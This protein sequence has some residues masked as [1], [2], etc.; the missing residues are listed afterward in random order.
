VIRYAVLALVVCGCA[1]Q[2]PAVRPAADGLS[3]ATPP[4]SLRGCPPGAAEPIAPRSPRTIEQLGAYALRL[5]AALRQTEHARAVC[6]YRL[7]R[8]NDWLDGGV[9]AAR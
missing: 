6:A 7:G 4:A 3:E 5:D 1:S 9:L 8:L 2:A